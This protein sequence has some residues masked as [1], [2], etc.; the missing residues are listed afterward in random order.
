M[1]QFMS[2]I[3]SIS[4]VVS[5]ALALSTEDRLAVVGAIHNSLADPT[6][7]HGPE[8]SAEAVANAWKEEIGKR[9]QDIENGTVQTIPADVAEQMIRGHDRPA[10]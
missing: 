2:A 9:I 3:P 4:D 1:E 10:I 8:E 7:D 6:V 5:S